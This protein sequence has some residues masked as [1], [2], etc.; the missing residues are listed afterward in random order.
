MRPL[1]FTQFMCPSIL[2]R[3]KAELFAESRGELALIPVPDPAR[4]LND[5]KRRGCEQL[6]RMLHPAMRGVLQDTLPVHAA[7]IIFDAALA[8]RK[9]LGKLPRRMLPRKVL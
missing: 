7:K 9:A 1:F 6:S 3:G 8:D 2:A 5:G 4:D